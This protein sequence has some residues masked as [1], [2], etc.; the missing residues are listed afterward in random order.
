[1][2]GCYY[3]I[4][5]IWFCVWFLSVWK[6][7]AKEAAHNEEENYRTIANSE[8]EADFSSFYYYDDSDMAMVTTFGMLF[9]CFFFWLAPQR[10]TSWHCMSG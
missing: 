2:A 10:K 4:F 8:C 6:L 3:F 5:S 9:I 7:I 1:M